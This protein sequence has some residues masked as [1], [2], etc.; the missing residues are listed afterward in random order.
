MPTPREDETAAPD[1]TVVLM[2]YNEVECLATVAAELLDA[3]QKLAHPAELLIVDDGS[4]DG[5]GALADRIASAQPGVRVLHHPGNLGLGGVYRSGF[6]AARGRYLT[7]F[8]AD[9][10]FPGA[11]LGDFRSCVESADLVLGYL[12]ER[13]GTPVAL[14]LSAVER[15]LYRIL[16]GPLPRFQGVFMIRRDVLLQIPLTSQGRGWAVLMELILRVSRGGYR[17]VVRPTPYR[18]RAT[19][20]SKVT[21]ARSALA[22][23]RQLL[24]LR[25]IL[26]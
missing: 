23:L 20:R 7:F 17:V 8:P 12:P 10:Q 3:L 18:P 14:A 25:R 19:G 26:R 2:T 1:L 9:G 22:N 6:S 4:T 21:N 15:L 24:A 13:R 11:I 16:L 5:S